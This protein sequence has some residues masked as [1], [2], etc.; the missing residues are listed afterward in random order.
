MGSL[1]L[2]GMRLV[3]TNTA[4]VEGA[5]HR[6]RLKEVSAKGGSWPAVAIEG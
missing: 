3:L 5:A 2:G 6:N 1:W 4:T